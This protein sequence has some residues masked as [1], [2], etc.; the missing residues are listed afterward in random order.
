MAGESI[1]LPII[2]DLGAP[3][4]P[5]QKILNIQRTGKDV[6]RAESTAERMMTL[7]KWDN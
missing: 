1:S 5:F 3:K 2:K 6:G 4:F 7:I